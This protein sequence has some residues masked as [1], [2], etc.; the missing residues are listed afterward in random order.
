M[1]DKIRVAIVQPKPYP[2]CDDPRNIGHA[3]LLLEKC[4]GEELDIICFPE[5]F[6]YLGEEELGAAA[7]RHETYILAGLVESEGEK[8]YNTATLFDRSGAIV[9]RQRKRNV[10]SRERSLLGISPGDGVY[11]AY[12][13]DFGKI[14]ISVGIDFWG[15]P[16]AGNQLCG[17]GAEIA[18]NICMFP[19]LRD[20]WKTGAIVRSFDN[21]VPVV[22][23]NTVSYN[24]MFQEKRV[25]QHGGGSFVISPPK[26][27]DKENFRR[28]LKSL[29]SC[30]SWLQIELD[31]LEL[32]QIAN[33]D[34]GTTRRY[35]RELWNHFGIQRR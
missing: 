2:S 27:I 15:Q 12:A 18:F 1:K 31:D 35:K 20:H 22:G 14:G 11:H 34:L 32:V 17:Q 5:L 7:Q 29:D 33:I 25:H 6:P 21:F 30:Q 10:T 3:L 19:H 24:A 9:G 8:L 16:E 13:T 26:I 28:W 4:R 23:V